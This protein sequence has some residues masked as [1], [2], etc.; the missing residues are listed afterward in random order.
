MHRSGVGDEVSH[1][2]FTAQG[3]GEQTTA[4]DC[5]R[6]PAPRSSQRPE[7]EVASVGTS[8]PAGT[9]TRSTA[10]F[11]ASRRPAQSRLATPSSHTFQSRLLPTLRKSRSGARAGRHRAAHWACS[12][13][14]GGSVC[15]RRASRKP[16]PQ[17][18]LPGRASERAS[19]GPRSWA[20]AP[21][22]HM[23]RVSQ[24]PA[25]QLASASPA[26][27]HRLPALPGCRGEELQRL[28]RSGCAHCPP[29]P[30]PGLLRGPG[31]T[32]APGTRPRPGSAARGAP[33]L[34]DR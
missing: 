2:P 19:D 31:P 5:P 7:K 32:L 14:R 1:P 18:R 12:A 21:R 13:G 15:A 26:S 24:P 4:S 16:S 20:H 6:C 22:G 23:P 8:P 34:A 10:Q 30:L 3:G 9:G 25:A 17:R 11:Q 28:P 27:R 33:L 29:G